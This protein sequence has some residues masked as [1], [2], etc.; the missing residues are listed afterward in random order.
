MN[1]RGFLKLLG[2]APV[3]VAAATPAAEVAPVVTSAEWTSA[4]EVL[5]AK[6]AG[7]EGILGFYGSVFQGLGSMADIKDPRAAAHAMLARVHQDHADGVDFATLKL[8]PPE[9]IVVGGARVGYHEGAT[10]A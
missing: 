5:A 1:R 7:D 9:P 2:L 10:D 6:V 4:P 3:A 8:H